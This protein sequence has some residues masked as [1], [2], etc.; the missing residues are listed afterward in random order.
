MF[1]V[2]TQ[3]GS[4]V[5]FSLHCRSQTKKK[6]NGVALNGRDDNVQALGH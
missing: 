6:E 3:C 4:M 1:N 5:I 2:H